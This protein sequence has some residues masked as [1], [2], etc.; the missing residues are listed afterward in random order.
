MNQIK[1]RS[2]DEVLK[3][4]IIIVDAKFAPAS[5]NT[6]ERSVD[7]IFNTERKVIMSPWY[8]EPFYE[9]LS[10][11]P[12]HIR[13]ERINAGIPVLDN[14]NRWGGVRQQLGKAE[15]LRFEKDATVTK[16]RFSRRKEVMDIFQDIADGLVDKTSIGYRVYKYEDITEDDNAPVKTFRAI[17][18]EP[19]EIS[20]VSIPANID[21]Q[22]RSENPSA[23]EIIQTRVDNQDNQLEKTNNPPEEREMS[24]KNENQIDQKKIEDEATQRAFAIMDLCKEHGMS[25]EFTQGARSLSID[26]VRKLILEEKVKQDKERQIS[27]TPKIEV[28]EDLSVKNRA[29]SIE[30]AILHRHNPNEYKLELDGRKYAN[31]SLLDLARVFAGNTEGLSRDEIARRALSTSDFPLI[32]AN[33]ANK[34]LRK[35]YDYNTDSF[36]AFVKE[37]S[38]SDFKSY[39]GLTLVDGGKL[40]KVLENGEYKKGALVESGESNKIETF[41]KIIAITRQTII[42]DDL[43]A[44]AKVPMLLGRSAGMLE[45]DIVYGILTGAVKMSDGKVLFHADHKNLTDPAAFNEAA[46]GALRK[47]LRQQKDAG[48]NP[49][50]VAMK[51]LIVGPELELEAEKLLSTLIL[52]ASVAEAN[53]FRN[54]LT[55]I[56]D[57]RITNKAFFGAADPNMCDTIEVAYLDGQR[58][59]KTE[60]KNGFEVDGVQIKV[61]HDFGAAPLDWRGLVKTPSV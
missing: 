16:L 28:G 19:Y 44:L 43:D 15:G 10:N 27:S 23:P 9:V 21:A 34:T 6:E 4:P 3:D 35:A 5:I 49:I 50:N 55:P 11:D 42:N 14:H 61:T 29:A 30:S 26:Q 31:A 22:V 41:G 47:L 18:W 54:K 20:L 8:D 46:V 36:R 39:K 56:V 1:Q 2:E 52:P 48:G 12:A 51:F 24:G 59:P 37:K 7:A 17:D 45:A 58:G 60:T 57:P 32:L 33:V 38:V 13:M 25:E 40:E 53:V